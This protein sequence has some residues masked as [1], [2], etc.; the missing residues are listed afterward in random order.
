[1]LQVC[2]DMLYDLIYVEL[3]QQ[4]TRNFYFGVK[5]GYDYNGWLNLSGELRFSS[6][7]GK[8]DDLLIMKPRVIFDLNAEVRPLKDLSVRVGYNFTQY[9]SGE[10]VGRL[11]NKNDLYM[12]ASYKINDRFGA[13]VQGNN[14]LDND[15][16]DYAGYETRGIRCMAG[17]TMNF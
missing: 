17:A 8:Y 14:L 3:A 2:G 11:H 10:N 13:F 5:G 4:D 7:D 6:W 9:T 16:F 15:Y 1:M 12:R